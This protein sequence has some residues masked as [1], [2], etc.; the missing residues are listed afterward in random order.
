MTPLGNDAKDVDNALD[1]SALPT[2][3]D[4]DTVLHPASQMPFFL[5]IFIL[6]HWKFIISVIIAL[7]YQTIAW[8]A[9][10]SMWFIDV[11]K[12]NKLITFW[13]QTKSCSENSP[14]QPETMI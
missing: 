12:T 4:A 13:K 3:R 7:W 2:R 6:P 10:R 5:S 1:N 11:S 8:N 14:F 9:L